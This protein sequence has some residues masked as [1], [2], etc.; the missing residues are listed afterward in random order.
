MKSCPIANHEMYTVCEDGTIHSGIHDITLTPS[1][2]PAGYSIVTLNGTQYSVH[3]IVALHFLPNPYQYKQVNHKDGDKS[4]NAVSNL[5]WCSAEYNNNHALETGL[6]KGYVHVDL[7]RAFLK[8]VLN[9]ETVLEISKELP[10][11][12]PNTLNR[13]LRKQAI[14]DG[15]E[16]EWTEEAKR[17]RRL[18]AL[19]NLE[20]INNATY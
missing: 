10:N 9:G 13:M 15:L 6:R 11:T 4:N 20:K 12:H 5:E 8:R 18:T 14:K 2:N 7:K 19:R 3:R 16:H 1:V 17:K